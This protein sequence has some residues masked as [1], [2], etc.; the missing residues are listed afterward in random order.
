MTSQKRTFSKNRIISLIIGCYLFMLFIISSITCYFA[1]G[2]TRNEIL[3]DI[4]M[5]LVETA[6]EYK[7]LTDNFWKFYMPFFENTSEYYAALQNYFSVQNAEDISPL[8]KLEL[9]S[10]FSKL[11][12]YDDRVQW[13]A[14][15]SPSRSVN[16]IYYT[17]QR[18]LLPLPADFPYLERLLSRNSRME[19]Y[20]AAPFTSGDI[21]YSNLAIAG[22]LPSDIKE[23]SLIVGYSL[24]QLENICHEHSLAQSLAFHILS[25]DDTLF[26]SN[27]LPVSQADFPATGKSCIKKISGKLYYLHTYEKQPNGVYVGYSIYFWELLLLSHKNTPYILFAVLILTLLSIALYYTILHLIAREVGI[28]QQGLDK[29]GQKQLDFRITD[30]FYQDSFSEI[31][32]SINS[33]AQSLKENI[34]RAYFYE[35]K[36]KEAELQELQAKFNPHF[37]Y[38][39]LELFRAKCC[40]NGDSETASLISQT[41]AIFRGFIGSRTFISIQ[42]ELAFSKRYLTLFRARFDDEAQV[43][44]DI[45]TEVLQYGIIRN[46]FQPLIE[47]YF[48]YGFNPEKKDN[49]ILFRG[50]IQDEDSILFEII[51]NGLGI[52]QEKLSEINSSLQESISTEKESY[53]LKNLHQRLH[54]FYGDGYRLEIQANAD[55]GI[56]IK[57]RIKRMKCTS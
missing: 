45:D 47:N 40:Q 50:R 18:L 5:T 38:N 10:F 49:F 37:L 32:A 16:Y 42:E 3:A 52:S 19:V 36:Q 15:I 43:L 39:S 53:G 13:V 29:L 21:T 41:A 54:L 27:D 31:A 48:S 24:T 34:D 6:G 23:G 56:T 8:D 51:D 26:S 14:A 30:S 12:I 57:M 35:I 11:T 33:M 46:V 44:Y 28:I 20:G 22:G 7:G 55:C 1:Y 9:A 25:D 4:D 17:D 2:R